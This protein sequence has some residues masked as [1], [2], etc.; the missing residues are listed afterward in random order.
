M[1]DEIGALHRNGTLVCPDG[2]EPEGDGVNKPYNCASSILFWRFFFF[3][4]KNWIFTASVA[5]TV[6]LVLFILMIV[7]CV[8][9]VLF[10]KVRKPFSSVFLNKTTETV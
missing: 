2:Y 1:E 5:G 7:G 10:L 4:I 3:L 8:S 6:V 9:F